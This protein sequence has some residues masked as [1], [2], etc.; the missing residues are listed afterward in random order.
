LKIVKFDISR[1]GKVFN[2]HYL[3]STIPNKSF[4]ADI[5]NIIG[6]ADFGK[7]DSSGIAAVTYPFAFSQ[8]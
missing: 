2:N 4:C 7:C 6:A 5:L 3:N 1:E 8:D